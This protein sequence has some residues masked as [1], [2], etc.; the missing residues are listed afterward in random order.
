M[1][2]TFSGIELGKRG[3][4]AHAQALQTAGHNISNV[5]TE[6]YSRQRVQLKPFDPIYFPGLNR[7]ETAGQIGQ[8]VSAERVERIR[9]MLLE[10]RIVAKANDSGYWDV[11]NKY[12]LMVEQVYNEP[13]EYSVR[14]QLD[15]F[16]ES[17]QELSL[18]PNESASRKS[19][20]QH[21]QALIDGIH[22]RFRTLTQ[23]RDNLEQDI[24]GT[25]ERINSV[26]EDVS[27]LNYQIVRS[28]A[29]DDNPNDLLDRRD[30]LIKELSGMIDIT[31]DN[32]DPDEFLVLTG[33]RHLIQGRN[34]HSLTAFPDQSNDGYSEVRWTGSDEAVSLRGGELAG[35]LELRDIDL[36]GEIQNLDTMTVN[37]IDL[38]NEVHR[39]AYGATGETG[40]DFF[41][42]YPFVNNTL[43]NYDSDGDGAFDSTYVFRISGANN[44]D[45]EEQ[46]GLAGT[47]TLS[48][49]LGNQSVEY[50]PT[51]TVGDIVKRI[52]NSGS[53]VVA[54]L[55]RSGRLTLKA[56]TADEP[57]SPDFV[58]RHVEDS[59]QF[60]V[61]Y[62]G[63]LVGSGPEGAY[64][65]D[66]A[67]AVLSL[68][69][70]GA[71]FAV[72]PLSHP[73]GW[74]EVNTSLQR[75]PG[76]LAAGFGENGRPALEGD[77]RAALAIA[78]LRNSPVMIGKLT[79]FD[80]FFADV[81]ADVG[82]RGEI[83]E[84]ASE[85]EQLIMKELEDMRSSIS[86]VNIDEELSE[87]IKFQHG[88]AAA[89][90]FISEMNQMLETIINRMGV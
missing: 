69:G 73:A 23:I 75:E 81:V 19:V 62:A 80:E 46:I 51:D 82:L 53:E 15:R 31:I 87:M 59:G 24:V 85:T 52:N 89:S 33:G 32:R 64:S 55:D 76:R 42:E 39:G 45:A 47:M 5:A 16:W 34:V 58:L 11:R 29:V 17:W 36:R 25:V 90:R 49:P 88:Y 28:E 14:A 56:T 35:L 4:M 41:V 1:Q 18:F 6:G 27:S 77:G 84:R 65:W 71:E 48:G 3:L 7:A 9:D 83:A 74:I 38:V 12:M 67:D 86:G 54:R 40:L 70:G 63:L 37:F 61:G 26:L 66:R 2:S 50:F 44:L 8:G 72:A 43:G 68:R 13:T 22:D 78:D 57:D 79:S 30:L 20:L 60:L 21:G 10:G